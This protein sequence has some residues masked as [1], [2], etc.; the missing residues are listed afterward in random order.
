VDSSKDDEV[1]TTRPVAILVAA[2]GL[3][4]FGGSPAA[5]VYRDASFGFL[6]TYPKTFH[7]APFDYPNPDQSLAG[8]AFGN[9]PHPDRL[10]H[11]DPSTL[12]DRAVVLL[13]EHS[14][15]GPPPVFPASGRDS[16]LPPARASFRP[17]PGT[18]LVSVFFVGNGWNLTARVLIG[19]HAGKADRDTVWRMVRSL[20]MRPLRL[21]ETTGEAP[22]VVARQA[23]SYPIVSV[24]KVGAVFLVHAPH[25]FYAV[26]QQL[27][28]CEL[29]FTLPVAFSC[30][31]GRH[32][33]RVGRPLWSNAS[34]NDALWFAPTVVAADGHV[35]VAKNA[36]IGGGTLAD[37]VERQVW[38]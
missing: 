20:R 5:R 12:G 31:D 35:L 32:W 7:V 28:S 15:G 4:A 30:P 11:G 34:P 21:G 33:D 24:T 37:D 38:G 3:V 29:M 18:R 14:A 16:K 36:E 19:P 26:A 17:L 27:P 6:V 2:L 23:R 25:G 8:A 10:V 9:V 22:Y 1:A 13:V